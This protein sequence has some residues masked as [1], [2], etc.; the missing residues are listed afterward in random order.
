MSEILDTLTS[1]GNSRLAKSARAKL[2][3]RDKKG[4]WVPYGAKLVADVRLPN[5]K[6]VRVEGRSAGGTATSKG[7]LNNIRLYVGKGYEDSGIEPDTILE[8]DPKNGELVSTIKLDRDYL[9]KHGVDPDAT[10][11]LPEDLAD[12]PQNLEDM[13]PQ[14]A[15]EE[16]KRLAGGLTEDEDAP[17]RAER[18]KEPVAKLAP[19]VAE[20]A[21][22]VEDILDKM[23][24]KPTWE[25]P[26]QPGAKFRPGIRQYGGPWDDSDYWDNPDGSVVKVPY[27]TTNQKNGE[28]WDGMENWAK[29]LNDRIFMPPPGSDL[30]INSEPYIINFTDELVDDIL[31]GKEIDL[32]N[33]IA[34]AKAFDAIDTKEKTA[35]QLVEGDVIQFSSGKEGIVRKISAK[36]GTQGSQLDVVVEDENGKR[37]TLSTDTAQK[38]NVVS[39]P[40]KSKFKKKPTP[41][42]TKPSESKETSKPTEP[43]KAPEAPEA[44]A[45]ETPEETSGEKKQ[46]LLDFKPPSEAAKDDGELI[47]RPEGMSDEVAR[48]NKGDF[49]AALDEDGKP[50]E[51]F[52][53]DGKAVLAQDGDE[54]LAEI[55]DKV[56]N[57]KVN[58]KGE[59]VIERS[60]FTD[61]DGTEYTLT[62]KIS[63]TNGGSFML[64]FEID[65]PDGSKKELWHYDVRDSYE[66]I[67][68][69]KNGIF[70]LTD[71]LA[72]RV[73]PKESKLDL[74]TY[75]EPGT[76][77]KRLDFLSAEK[78]RTVTRNK[79]VQKLEKAKGLPDTNRKKQAE[80]ARAE[81]HLRKF[82]T[83]FNGDADLYTE[84]AKSQTARFMTLEQWMDR[85]TSGNAVKFNYSEGQLANV[86]RSSTDSIYESLVEGKSDDVAFRLQ[87]L[88]NN[89]PS[90]A[91]N[92]QTAQLLLDKIRQNY[93]KRYPKENSRVL[94][95]LTTN[96]WKA[97]WDSNE[98][99]FF[100]K[101]HV[102]Y[103]GKVLKEGDIVEFL[104]NDDKVS[105]GRIRKIL[106]T[107]TATPNADGKYDYKDYVTV[108]YLDNKGNITSEAIETRSRSLVFVAE[109]TGTDA[110]KDAMTTYTPWIKGDEKVLK[111]LGEA[112]KP[113]INSDG[114]PVADKTKVVPIDEI[115]DTDTVP[116]LPNDE[117]NIDNASVGS[118]FI[119]KNGEIVG[120]IVAKKPAKDKNGNP[121]F[122]VLYKD[123]D[124]DLKKTVVKRGE[125]RKLKK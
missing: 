48:T 86:L 123:L 72:G 117:M 24:P 84:W 14:P 60:K 57:A 91:R 45:P 115:D 31:D 108:E 69:K 1:D 85:Q 41:P 122:A 110:D 53:K 6:V 113:P 33:V 112:K 34:K 3:P 38:V 56:P 62:S 39:K 40:D 2:Q 29:G 74:Q 121:V 105:I 46:R 49:Q 35:E 11:D 65:M 5:G 52:D 79:L 99:T 76:L 36:P 93:K 50:L 8:V 102:S 23:K 71:Q 107:E 7:Q 67:F 94:G 73:N 87:A 55:L 116:D 27:G 68:G 42:R 28:V 83:E 96:A 4:R 26:I 22:K 20:K 16:D 106:Q 59:I 119:N 30:Q 120:D 18:E 64:G 37:V 51:I 32:D 118:P 70:A 89:L 13:N 78:M 111:R 81:Y 12:Q 92:E 82:D 104:N 43:A 88:A 103:D 95:A 100:E 44:E 47:E 80:I 19:A 9:E 77:A 54:V 101:P 25:R 90:W 61:P 10:A 58:D 125:V 124:G 17:L 98:D 109:G 75:F 66:A 15:T 21:T 97:L 114:L 63:R